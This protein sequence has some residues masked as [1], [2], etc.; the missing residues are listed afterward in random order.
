MVRL[1][2]SAIL[3][4][5]FKP[6]RRIK[7][8]LPFVIAQYIY[9]RKIFFL[10]TVLFL[11]ITKANAQKKPDS[12]TPK[13]SID[14]LQE[15]M[16]MLDSANRPVSYAFAN[17]AVGNRLFS[18]R[19]NALNAK[20]NISSTII[21]SPSLGYFHKTG[22]N[23]I[24][25]AN[26]LNDGD[27]FGVNQYSINPAYDLVGN[28]KFSFGISYTHYFVKDK[29]SA[30]SSPI[31][32][33]FYTSFAYKKTWL[34]P[35]VSFGYST[36]EYKE[37]Q[38]KDTV[39]NNGN[40]HRYDSMTNKLNAFSM[41]LTASHEFAWY[42]VF[43]KMDGLALTP[44]IMVNAGAAK[45]STIHKTNAPIINFLLRKRR[46]P[47]LQQDKFSMQSIGL[48]LDLNYTVGKL[49]LQ[50]QLYMD[51]YLPQTDSEKFSQVF[52]FN[53]GYAF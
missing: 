19:N 40:R 11:F 22:F 31:Q 21:Y 3:T 30:F 41:M 50:P 45:T 29:F 17:V 10:V 18:T 16:D 8:T 24:A 14:I 26:L 5:N 28:R 35:G 1:N 38:Y 47:K 37:V 48:N 36:G 53:I 49:T 15:L 46:I 27:K 33:D 9:M 52:T 44:T 43:A 25:G 2:I 34:R 32:N 13:D 4:F 7:V 39:I 20:Q 12:L 51:Y 42:A 23:I 6:L